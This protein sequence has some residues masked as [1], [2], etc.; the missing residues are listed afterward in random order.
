MKNK[1]ILKLPGENVRVLIEGI[2]RAEIRKIVSSDPFI[3][4]EVIESNVVLSKRAATEDEI[5]AAKRSLLESFENYVRLSNRVPTETLFAIATTKDAD[6]ITFE[7]AG[8]LPISLEQRQFLLDE[9]NVLERIEMLLGFLV[10]E[11]EILQIEKK[12]NAKVKNQID[13]AEGNL[14][15]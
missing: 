4:A 6:K 10:K 12:I 9:Q 5:E 15:S 11:T 8:S 13:S 7:I 3:K 14:S 1:Q 2:K